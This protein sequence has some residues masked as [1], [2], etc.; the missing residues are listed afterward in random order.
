[1]TRTL[2]ITWDGPESAYLESLTL[3]IFTALHPYGFHFDVLQFH[4]D[5]PNKVRET[6]DLCARSGIGYRGVRVWRSVPGIGSLLSALAG[7]WRIDSAVSHFGSDVLLPR[8]TIPALT[9][10]RSRAGRHL[11]IVFDADG[12]A[13]D[14]KIEF[15]DGASPFE[16]RVMRDVETRILRRSARVLVRS[17]AAIPTL[18]ARAG[19]LTTEP[20]YILF[21]NGR[22]PEIFAPGIDTERLQIRNQ[23]QIGAD[24]PI[25]LYVGTLGGGR[26]YDIDGLIAVVRAVRAERPD[27]QFLLLT[28]Q[29]EE[30]TRE[31]ER[32]GPDL[33]PHALI[34]RVPP[35][36]MPRWIAAADVGVAMISEG[37]STTAVQPIKTAEYLLCGV[38]VIG[39][40]GIGQTAAAE[41]VG[42]FKSGQE[43][44]AAARWFAREVLPNRERFRTYA[45]TAGEEM[46][47]LSK[48]AD[49]LREALVNLV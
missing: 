22:D 24:T 37:F 23:L 49:A 9:T 7:G 2:F 12:L 21:T 41:N 48:A 31:L 11:P 4:W 42:V 18:K 33:L 15:V 16:Y 25:I 13:A 44:V 36:E 28:G 6:R 19:P 46:F 32:H 20:D 27:S 26:K 45:R 1:M 8:S 38:P 34:R 14:E 39:T 5:E 29:I 47:S 10:L 30:A 35:G 40:L 17:P 3:P 43:P